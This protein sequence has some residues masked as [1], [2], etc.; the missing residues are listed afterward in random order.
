MEFR[1]TNVEIRRDTYLSNGTLAVFLVREGTE[2]ALFYLTTNID[3]SSWFCT[4]SDDNN[5]AFVDNNNYPEAESFLVG[6]GFAKAVGYTAFCNYPLYE[7]DLDKIPV[8]PDLPEVDENGGFVVTV[9]VNFESNVFQP[10]SFSFE[11]KGMENVKD[12]VLP[13]VSEKC[14]ENNID[15]ATLCITATITQNG[16]WVDTDE[17]WFALGDGELLMLDI[18]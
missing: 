17:A 13:K 6:N 9:K 3:E 18:C 16:N 4:G 2:E 15:E 10:F 8:S 11:K 5:K 7:F 12:D 1:K 14:K